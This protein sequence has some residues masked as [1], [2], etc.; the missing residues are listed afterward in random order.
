MIVLAWLAVPIGATILAIAWTHWTSR[1]RRPLETHESVADFEKF[2]TAMAR[3]P[4]PGRARR[5]RVRD[6]QR[7]AS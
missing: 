3:Q 1:P 5:P 6:Q 4:K 7:K 2:R